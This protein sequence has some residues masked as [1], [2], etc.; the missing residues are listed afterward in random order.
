MSFEMR[1]F[2]TTPSGRNMPDPRITMVGGTSGD[3]RF[4][5]ALDRVRDRRY[6][7]AVM[8]SAASCW[9]WYWSEIR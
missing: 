2:V 8:H 5:K 7:F 3:Y 6:S 1:S 9:Y 4:M